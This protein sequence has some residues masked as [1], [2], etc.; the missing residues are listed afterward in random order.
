MP[1]TPQ[2]PARPA[3]SGPTAAATATGSRAAPAAVLLGF[4]T[5]TLDALIVNVALPSIRDGLG[6]G[7]SGLQ[8]VVDGYTLAFAAF[9][10]S[11]GSISDRI[12]ARQA[13][14]T[15]LALFTAA[16]VACGLAPG[17]GVLVAARIVQG[18]GAA[19]VLPSSL[20]LLRET[21]PDPAR[22]AKAIALWG[23]G[24]S[25]GS[26]AGPVAGGLLTMADWRLIFFVN[27]PVGAAALLLLRRAARSPARPTPFDWTGQVT[28]VVAMG[29][30]TF[31]AIE[32]GA[33]G[34]TTTPVLVALAVTVVAASVFVIA[35]AR[36]RH[37]MTPLPLLRSRV[38]SLS[39]AVGF[40]LNVAFYGMIFL[41]GLY[42]QQT[43]GLNPL[44]TGIA[45]L[46][47]ALTAAAMGPAAARLANRFGARTP[48][49]LGQVLIV[50]G[51]LAMA[52]MPATAS[53][54]L[55]VVLMVP[56]GSGGALAVTALTALV[57]ESV[58]TERAGTAGGVL[59]T[60]RQ[61]GGALAVAV[62][63]ALVAEPSGFVRGLRISLL[64]AAAT[65]LV[66][67]AATLRL[68]ALSAREDHHGARA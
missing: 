15:G 23:V 18:V 66:T 20:A 5:I 26:A 38:M 54:W 44:A 45:F 9:L 36:G 2:A 27:L 16:S 62:F 22:R 57:L 13:F 40:A 1:S 31:A 46:P 30:L 67:V 63:G 25:V 8:W 56:I 14:A 34:F 28:A 11:A 19:L 68:R 60:S 55:L 29:A 33:D 41:I 21:F 65:V 51:L 53:V 58:P 4:F 49:V 59:N 3:V 61:T 43:R 52:A 7:M 32:G 39:S 48:I 42:L 37:P 47:M 12:G 50:G 17:L 10:L 64:I 24:G 35:Q 6:G